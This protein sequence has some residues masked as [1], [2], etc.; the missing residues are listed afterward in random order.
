MALL[1]Y[2]KYVYH[3]GLP[4]SLAEFKRRNGF[5][6]VNIPRYYVPLTAKGRAA[7]A[8]KLHLDIA[9]LL[10]SGLLAAAKSIRNRL[11]QPKQQGEKPPSGNS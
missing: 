4:D 11:T 9:E 8:L 1:Q 7:I 6:Q 10:P 2:R 5:E 3:K